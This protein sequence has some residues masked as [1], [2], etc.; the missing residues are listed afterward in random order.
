MR[1]YNCNYSEFDIDLHAEIYINYLEVIITDDGVIHYAHPSH[2]MFLEKLYKDKFSED[3]FLREYNCEE[4][5]RDYMG[6]LLKSTHAIAVWQTFYMG[7]ANDKQIDSLK[8]LQEKKD[9]I[10]QP[11]YKGGLES[12]VQF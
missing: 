6:W 11:L 2:Q 9:K 10:N 3:Q 7:V 4:A 5:W 12:G 8:K 1:D